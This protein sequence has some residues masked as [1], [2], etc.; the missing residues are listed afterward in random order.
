MWDTIKR[1]SLRIIGIDEGEFQLKGSENFFN[2]ITKERYPNLKTE[3]Q[4]Q[5]A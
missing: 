2:K 1:P 4:V 3:I 5:E